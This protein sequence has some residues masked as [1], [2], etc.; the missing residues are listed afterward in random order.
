MGFLVNSLAS[1]FLIYTY[2][3]AEHMLLSGHIIFQEVNF[4]DWC[5]S[6]CA[7]CTLSQMMTLNLEFRLS[8]H[9]NWLHLDVP[10]RVFGI[11]VTTTAEV[12]TVMQWIERPHSKVIDTLKQ[13]DPAGF[14]FTSSDDTFHQS[15]L[16]RTK[17]PHLD[18]MKRES[19]TAVKT[20]ANLS[21][22]EQMFL[23]RSLEKMSSTC[24]LQNVTQ[25]TKKY[26][27]HLHLCFLP[28]GTYIFHKE[29]SKV[30]SSTSE[31]LKYIYYQ[32]Q[33]AS[34]NKGTDSY[35]FSSCPNLVH[36][37]KLFTWIEA[38]QFCLSTRASLPKFYDR[39]DQEDFLSAMKDV[40]HLFPIEAV[41]IGLM[42]KT[43]VSFLL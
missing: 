19:I 9:R 12:Q 23:D 21:E 2:H 38:A 34:I 35:N 37:P 42:R 27:R 1:F 17:L 30:V 36:N 13:I 10:G 20:I 7:N 24:V 14:T 41:Y 11:N 40:P 39:E 4:Y 26:N 15:A 6:G 29:F 32:P 5:L 22:K 18:K 43:K 31:Y 33:T 28:K 16:C 8:Q 3:F 25:K